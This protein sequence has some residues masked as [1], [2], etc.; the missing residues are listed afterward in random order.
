MAN[1]TPQPDT[2][3]YKIVKFFNKPIVDQILKEASD[4]PLVEGSGTLQGPSS[5]TR[6][7]K[8]LKKNREYGGQE[9]S[10]Y[11]YSLSGPEFNLDWARFT[12]PKGMSNV[13]YSSM[14]KGDYYKPHID[15][16]EL[17]HFSTTIFLNNPKTYVGGEL[18]LLIDGELKPFKLRPGY[19]VVYETGTPHQVKEVISGERKV[20]VF[21]TTSLI[22]NMLDLYSYR[23]WEAYGMKQLANKNENFYPSSPED[24]AETLEEFM[25]KKP[26]KALAEMNIIHRKYL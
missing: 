19:G 1:T 14:R 15:G 2:S 16:G 20:L 10:N 5:I 12:K 13:I 7:A 18:E 9:F 3:R 26:V 25:E 4:K 8:A 21:W 11:I 6:I 17:G 22:S 23:A 24:V